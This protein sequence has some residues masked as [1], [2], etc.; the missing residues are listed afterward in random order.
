[1]KLIIAG[2]RNIPEHIAYAEC[3]KWRIANRDKVATEIVSGAARGVDT[4]GEEY[5]DYYD[6][7]VKRFYPDWDTFG[8]S[9][10]YRRNLEM[11]QYAD[12]LLLI[13]DGESKG[14]G[15]MKDIMRKL[16]KPI[17]EIVIKGG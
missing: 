16:N 12:A 10:G 6:I 7:P 8:K 15:H 2:G 3:V 1:M 11:G 17:Y 4:A 5:A 14:S 13:W 9:A